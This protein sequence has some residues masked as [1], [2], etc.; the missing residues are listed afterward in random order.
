M[1]PE[2]DCR[3]KAIWET[4]F[5]VEDIKVGTIVSYTPT[6]NCKTFVSTYRN[7]VL[8]EWGRRPE[9]AVAHRVIVIS[10]VGD[11]LRYVLK[12]DA[13]S[14]DDGCL[15]EFSSIDSYIIEIKKGLAPE[16]QREYDEGVR[17]R[18]TLE[19]NLAYFNYFYG[20]TPWNELDK[21]G[22][23]LHCEIYWAQHPHGFCIWNWE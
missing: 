3:D 6:P 17:K 5:G 22:R 8:P 10:G 15:V 7:P 23:R 20:S 1:E 21:E 13:N 9:S 18:K 12:G 2:I 4:N 11:T 14:E 16:N 19:M